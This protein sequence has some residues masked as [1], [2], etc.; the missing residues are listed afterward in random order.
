MSNPVEI[1]EHK[2]EH[3][4]E[5]LEHVLPPPRSPWRKA[6]GIIVWLLVALYFFFAVTF[7]SL[8]YWVLPHISDYAQDIAATL[9]RNVGERVTIGQID[10]GWQG[11]HPYLELTDLRIYDRKGA[12]AL[13]LPAVN[14]K[15][16]W[17]SLPMAALR[18]HSL[19]FVAPTLS[20]RRDAEGRFFVAGLEIKQSSGDSGFAD[21]LLAQREVGIRDARIS[22]L[23]EQR[24]APQLDLVDVNFRLANS[25]SHHRFALKADPPDALA[26]ELDVRGDFTGDTVTQFQQ[27][28]GQLYS[29]FEYTDLAEWQRWIDYP[30][31]IQRGKGGLR[32]WLRLAA[33]RPTEIVADVA[34]ARL[35][36]RFA[37][38]LPLL[39]LESLQGRVGA[40]SGKEDIE[41]FGKR[42]AMRSGTGV[43]LA[44]ADFDVTLHNAPD[45]KT[46]GGNA[47]ANGLEIEPLAWLADY[48][49]LAAEAR[50]ALAEAKPGG[51]INELKI[52]WVGELP[53]PAQFTVRG[54]FTRLSMNR[55]AGV[56]GFSGLT[57]SIDGNERSGSLALNSEKAVIDLAGMLSDPRLELDTLTGQ[58]GWTR[59]RD[60]QLEMRVANL[61]VANKDVAG[62][63]F[64]SWIAA[65]AGPG[66][67]DIT[68]RLTR[69]D[70]SA[71]HRY[72]PDFIGPTTVNWLKRALVVANSNDVRF[73]IKGDLREFPW[74]GGK[75]GQFQVVAKVRDG[76]LDYAAGWPRITGIA[77]DLSLEGKRLLLTASRGSILGARLTGVKV[78]IADLVH[79]DELLTIE[80][81]ADGPT[82]EFFKFIDTS[83][84]AG[85]ID[86]FTEHA[87]A[88]GT[89]RLQLRMDLPLRRLAELK[90]AGNYQ[91]NNNQVKLDPDLPPLSQVN[92]RLDFTQ[93]GVS[94]RAITAQLLGGSLTIAA[95]TR[96]GLL[97]VNA[98]GT[99]NAAGL[100][101]FADS[102]VTRAMQGATPYR[103]TIN[104]KKRAADLLITSDLQG[105]A[106]DLP[107]PLNKAANEILPLRLERTNLNEQEAARRGVRARPEVRGGVRA[108]VQGDAIIASLGKI[109]SVQLLRRKEGDDYRILRGGIAFNEAAS[110]PDRF[111][112]QITGNVRNL[113]VD[114]WRAFVPAPAAA[115]TGATAPGAE[116]PSQL[117]N[118]ANLRVSMLDAGGKRFNE[119][120]VRAARGNNQWQ[121]TVSSRE[122]A[123]E[124]IWR[125]AGRGSLLARLKHLSIPENRPGAGTDPSP[126]STELP[127]IDLVAENFVT[128]EKKLGRLE[129]QAVNEG[130]EW[131]IEKMLLANP[132]GTLSADG[133]WKPT[134]QVSTSL[135]VKLDVSD[136]G[137]YLDRMG[138]PGTVA[139]GT[140]KIEGKLAWA[141]SPQGLDYPSL[142]GNLKLQVEKGQFLKV[143]PGI[144]KLIGI[145]SLQA[146]PKRIA[147]DFRDV[148][149]DGFAF[150]SIQSTISINR[151]IASTQDFAMQGS[152]AAVTIKGDADLARETQNLQVRV[153]P[154]L[155]DSV[156]TVAGLLLANPI[157]GI[158]AMLAQRLFNNPLG[159]IFAYDYAVTGNWSDP[160]VEKLSRA[161][162]QAAQETPQGAR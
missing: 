20:I 19:E 74:D 7:L 118:A 40:R 137:K 38:E 42:I 151:G 49:P 23:D 28:N 36:T 63:A 76:T 37:P 125:S 24:K 86:H 47:H 67:V 33:G 68:A 61:S 140:A 5:S 154:A 75:N 120:S 119:V 150:D 157:T 133:A 91:F 109:V 44:P 131:R 155:G 80:G 108:E 134:G 79:H 13:A 60:G 130:G 153:I 148:F 11:L 27:W 18:F 45:G 50:K 70:V 122:F 156:S 159:Q 73:R 81:N 126:A 124:L 106:L 66:T 113:D 110:V 54:R 15:V 111:G 112:L 149:S 144:A 128:R 147:L 116:D 58:L 64:G 56:P 65:A 142:T 136:V 14:A 100:K 88:E 84:V 6:M 32:L 103:A 34:M 25:G 51:A 96:E 48:L 152:A 59:L 57:G 29:E 115:P 93:A 62:T 43:V 82:A 162:P 9:S 16:S 107:A 132:E 141:G 160:K 46:R 90:V 69:A 30:L 10:A 1:I 78:G 127:A 161:A 104:I 129:L 87:R 105:L 12:V 71:A 117:V 158:G 21:W 35:A 101:R 3:V 138:S 89:G 39:E 72:L 52:E 95:A 2:I 121:A 92:G 41:V 85:M 143:E 22:W 102:P 83:P 53:L 99:L 146:L 17:W 114:R 26:S 77:A 31:E 139:R 145:L 135:N 123:G 97:S 98:Q 4:I 55:Y 8:R 94:V